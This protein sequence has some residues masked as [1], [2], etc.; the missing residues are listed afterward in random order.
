MSDRD[1][2]LLVIGSGPGGYVSAIRAS[3]LGMKA[4]IVERDKPGGVCLNIGCIPSK[5]LIHQAEVFRSAASLEAMGVAVDASGFD[6][7]KVYKASRSAADR[8]SKGVAHLLK[9]NKVDLISGTGKPVGPHEVSVD[10]KTYSAD[11]VLLATGSRPRSI[12]GFEID[13]KKV[14]SSTGALMLEKLPESIV[15]L[16]GGAIGAEFAHIFNSFGSKVTLVEMLPGILPLEDPEAAAVLDKDFRGRGI[17]VY[18]GTSARGMKSVK[19]GV[20]VELSSSEGEE[21][22]SLNAEKLLVAVGRQPNTEE[23]GLEDLGIKMEKGYVRT[24]DYYQTDVSS[25]YAIGDIIP[26]VQLAHAAS[27]EGEIAV[28]HMAGKSVPPELDP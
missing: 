14:L 16:G 4:G 27:G 28:S 15:I 3:Q 7:G 17:D 6:Y 19:S 1:Y 11:A 8:L 24:R 18:T 20:K 9:K 26:T 5:A 13:E 12:P 25:I 21:A 22:V 10:G 23:L 2:D